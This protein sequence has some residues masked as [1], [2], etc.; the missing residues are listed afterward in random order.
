[1]KKAIKIA[2]IVIV[3]VYALLATIAARSFRIEVDELTAEYSAM[4][5]EFSALKEE[6]EEYSKTSIA[7][8]VE[9]LPY[10]L[11]YDAFVTDILHGNE[12]DWDKAIDDAAKEYNLSDVDK[13]ILTKNISQLITL[14]EEVQ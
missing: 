4:N 3:V 1:M 12:Y 8:P 2:L 7:D 6:Y 11:F 5:A 9:L 13:L 14:V 10:K